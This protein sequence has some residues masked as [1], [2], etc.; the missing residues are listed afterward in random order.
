MNNYDAVIKGIL[1]LIAEVWR[2]REWKETF[3]KECAGNTE[4]NENFQREI[5]TLRAQLDEAREVI[6]VLLDQVDYTQ[7]ACAPTE[8]VGAVLPILVI[9]KARAYLEKYPI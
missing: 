4:V 1:E 5:H 7:G 9:N 3:M 6:G 2:E 8:M